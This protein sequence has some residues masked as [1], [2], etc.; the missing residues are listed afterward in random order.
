MSL[1]PLGAARTSADSSAS[2]L[3][4]PAARRSTGASSW[5]PRAAGPPSPASR[6]R[7]WAAEA[8]FRPARSRQFLTH[9]PRVCFFHA[10]RPF[11]SVVV[12][13]HPPIELRQQFLPEGFPSRHQPR[14]TAFPSAPPSARRRSSIDDPFTKPHAADSVRSGDRARPAHRSHRR[15]ADG[16]DRDA[17]APLFPLNRYGSVPT[18]HGSAVT[19]TR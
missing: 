14:R 6:D 9:N 3:P 7:L 15:D 10:L 5:S 19:R 13:A 16:C 8:V 17:R 12:F 11:E 2:K 1:L 18:L 4:F